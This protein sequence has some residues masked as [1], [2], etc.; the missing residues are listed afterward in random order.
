MT[1][2]LR[3]LGSASNSAPSAASCSGVAPRGRVPAIGCSTA[4]PLVTV[5]SASGEDPTTS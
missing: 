4:R 1:C 2:S 3:S 5:T